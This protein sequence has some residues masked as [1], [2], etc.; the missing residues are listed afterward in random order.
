MTLRAP[1]CPAIATAITP[2]GPAP[3]IS[4]SSPTMS[5]LSAVCVALPYGSKI[6]AISSETAAG[7]RN[8][9]LAGSARYSAKEPGRLT[10]TPIVSLHRCR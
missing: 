2:I 5:K 9:L 7:T 4:T 10:P 8:R 1:T 3:V 6:V